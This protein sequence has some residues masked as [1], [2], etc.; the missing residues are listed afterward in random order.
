MDS[1]NL[2]FYSNFVT[3]SALIGS[4]LSSK[5]V[6][7]DKILYYVSFQQLNVQLSNWQWDFIDF[8]KKP[9]KKQEKLL[10]MFT[11]F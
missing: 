4:F 6:F 2:E 11:L 1:A 7:M 3:S 8:I 5:R 9:T 10:T